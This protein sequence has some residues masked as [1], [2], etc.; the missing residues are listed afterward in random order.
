MRLA[1]TVATASVL[2][3]VLAATLFDVQHVFLG[4]R[5][6]KVDPVQYIQ[7][8][9]VSTVSPC[10]WEFDPG[11]QQ[12]DGQWPKLRGQPMPAPDPPHF[13]PSR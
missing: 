13:V 11:M 3:G 12:I 8:A 5:R 9:A 4:M 10:S 6:H 7:C 2:C 1:A